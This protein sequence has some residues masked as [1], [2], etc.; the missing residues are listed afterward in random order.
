MA[1]HSLEIVLFPFLCRKTVGCGS[2]V[3]FA[4]W[5]DESLRFCMYL[6][7]GDGMALLFQ[8]EPY[9]MR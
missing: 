8:N 9:T 7:I 4:S 3:I 6:R 5:Q 1:A 2:P